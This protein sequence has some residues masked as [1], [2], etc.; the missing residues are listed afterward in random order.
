MILILTNEEDITTDFVVRELRRDEFIRVNTERLDRHGE[1]TYEFDNDGTL[2]VV[3][4]EGQQLPAGE[5]SAVYCRRSEIPDLS[6]IRDPGI[7]AFARSE[8][9]TLIDSLAHLVSAHWINHPHAVRRAEAKP[10]QLTVAKRCG[11]R[12]PRSII[13]SD[14]ARAQVFARRETDGIIV[15]ALT[16]PR[17]TIG[18]RDHI[19]FTSI[20][21][22]Q[23]LDVLNDVRLAPC[24]IQQHIPKTLDLRVTV[25]GSRVFAVEI[26]SQSIPDAVIDW[27]AS[28][29]VPHRVHRLPS[30]VAD[31]SRALCREL[32]LTFG[33]LDFVVDHDGNYV[34]LEVNPVGQWAW[35]E[36]LTGVPIAATLADALRGS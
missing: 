27:R 11:L 14:P 3:G 32:G 4:N 23:C 35:L 12:V 18:G 29:D 24:I 5:I 30:N 8:F 17:V 7:R 10:L 34:F 1:L 6:E 15:K 21:L 26:D 2:V 28:V 19:M 22:P 16:S 9:A 13:T 25:V 33:A 36:L 31:A 20:V